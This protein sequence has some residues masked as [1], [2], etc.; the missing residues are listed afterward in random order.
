MRVGGWGEGGLGGDI[1]LATLFFLV[2]L[3]LSWVFGL[4]RLESLVLFENTGF[5]ATFVKNT[6]K[7]MGFPKIWPK[8]LENTWFLAIFPK[9]TKNHGFS[10]ILARNFGIHRVFGHFCQNTRKTMGFPKNPNLARD[11]GDEGGGG[12]GVGG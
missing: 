12:W 1:S 3:E 7:T 5:S 10:K 2:S 4:F 8:I 6:P 9:S 11:K